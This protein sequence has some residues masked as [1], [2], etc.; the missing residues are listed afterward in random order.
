MIEVSPTSIVVAQSGLPGLS[1]TA[2]Q[3]FLVALAVVVFAWGFERYRTHFSRVELVVATTISLGILTVGV[4]PDV[5]AAIGN[6]L[7]LESRSLVVSLIANTLFAFLILY[8]IA[9][10][11]NN[12][13]EIGELT[14]QLAIREVD[15]ADHDEP[16]I[17]VVI[18]AY[19][20]ADSVRD[21]VESL[22]ASL[23]GHR[24]EA[25]VVSDGS[26]D[27]TRAAAADA[28]AV[29]TEHPINQGQGGALKTGFAIAR[30]RAADVV[31][32][33]DADGQHSAA[34][35]E[36]L[37]API[38]E[39][40][41]DYVL[42]T[43]Y[44]GEDRSGNSPTRRIG[45]RVFTVLINLVSK[46]DVTDCTNGYRAIRGSR[47]EDLTLTEERFNAPEL[48]IE[49]RKNGLRIQEV[50]VTVRSREAGETKKPKLRYA[51]GLARTIVVTWIR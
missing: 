51:L 49:A 24:V 2:L 50:P 13:L 17:A 9:L 16:T 40:R 18:P 34:D 25:I 41:A 31:V 38:V 23:L 6:V 48:I 8:A 26:T 37:V 29:V 35:L 14:R 22:P 10:I 33:M 4:F 5:F 12:Q 47:L 1:N 15:E 32:T 36:S 11:R 43:R 3:V 45:I 20:E 44:R 7:N 27:D 19:N 39:D 46:A 28:D 21:V 30:Q 42:G